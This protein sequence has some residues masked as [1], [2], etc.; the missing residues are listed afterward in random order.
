MKQIAILV[1]ISTAML[2]GTIAAEAADSLG[3]PFDGNAL[4]NPNWKWKTSREEGVEPEEWDIGKTKAGWL[5]R[6][7]RTQPQPLAR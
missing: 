3:D 5:H 1:L 2:F 7:R 4:K 6:H